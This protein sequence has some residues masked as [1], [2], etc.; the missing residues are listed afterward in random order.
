MRRAYRDARCCGS[1]R[2]TSRR[3][4]AEPAARASR[5]R[6]PTWPAP[7]SRPRS[8]W[9]ARTSTTTA[10]GSGW[11]SSA[12]ASAAGASSTTSATSTSSTSPSRPRGSTR[13]TALAGRR[14]ARGG[15]GAGVLDAVRA[16]R[17]CGRSTPRCAPR[18]RTARSSARWPATGRT[19]SAGP[20]PGSS[21]RCSRPARRRR[22]GAR[23]AVRRVTQPVRVGRRTREDFV[24]DAQAMRRRVEEHVPGRGGGPPAQARRRRAARRRVHRPAAPA[25]ARP[26]GRVDPQRPTR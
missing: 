23:R 19:T 24:E 22:P 9:P 11:P 12:W 26:G 14:A 10:P 3:R 7:R 1:P 13:P 5:R 2:P 16:S 25:G 8:R 20:R 4:P 18:A 17:R 15:P 21:R 6:S